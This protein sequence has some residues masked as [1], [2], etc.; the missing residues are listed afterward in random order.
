[1]QGA[2]L[3]APNI[4]ARR[5]MT[6]GVLAPLGCATGEGGRADFT[7]CFCGLVCPCWLFGRTI[8]RPGSS[9]QSARLAGAVLYLAPYLLV[10]IIAA[11]FVPGRGDAVGCTFEDKGTEPGYALNGSG[12][13]EPI[14]WV[15]LGPFKPTKHVCSDKFVY[16][17]QLDGAGTNASGTNGTRPGAVAYL[18]RTWL[19]SWSFLSGSYSWF[20]ATEHGFEQESDGAAPGSKWLNDGNCPTDGHHMYRTPPG[21]CP[22]S[23]AGCATSGGHGHTP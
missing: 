1:M 11:L 22:Q 18:Y 4:D 12:A 2:L 7:T 16:M 3:D 10:A 9:S 14:G 6:R 17:A 20:I 19:P 8:R 21:S 13:F 23:P 15:G 5:V